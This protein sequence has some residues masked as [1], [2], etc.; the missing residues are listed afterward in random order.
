MR[1][2]WITEDP[3]GAIT[4]ETEAAAA[5][6][7]ATEIVFGVPPRLAHMIEP[8]AVGLAEFDDAI[9]EPTPAPSPYEVFSATLRAEL[10]QATTIAKMRTA[11]TSALDALDAALG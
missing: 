5:E 6:A 1:K 9:D 7:G 10:P 11:L 4:A 8:G 2:I 3:F